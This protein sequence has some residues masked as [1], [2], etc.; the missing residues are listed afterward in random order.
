MYAL[1]ACGVVVAMAQGILGK[2]MMKNEKLG[3]ELCDTSH[4][5]GRIMR[6]KQIR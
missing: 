2:E 5:M 1:V 6:K 4:M 3:A